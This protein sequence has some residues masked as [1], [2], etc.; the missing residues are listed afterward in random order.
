MKLTGKE[1]FQIEKIAKALANHQRI[2]ILLLLE[3]KEE[4]SLGEIAD[5]FNKDYKTIAEHT[6]RLVLGGLVHKR[7]EGTIVYFRLSPLGQNI[8]K[9]LP[10]FIS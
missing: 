2:K 9:I 7:R 10:E 5:A 3:D 1:I 4:M 6:R 8:L